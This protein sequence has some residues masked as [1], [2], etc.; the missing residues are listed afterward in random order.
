VKSLHRTARIPLRR[1]GSLHVGLVADTHSL[2]HQDG[3]AFLE[4]AEP[5]LILHA[6][7]IGDLQVLAQLETLAPVHAVRGN[8]DVRAAELP[9]VLTVEFEHQGTLAFT[10]LLLHI[11]VAGARIRADASRLAHAAGA[12]LIVCGHSHIPFATQ[13]RGLTL[14]NPGSM[15]PRRFRL[16]IV[17]GLMNLTAT[18]VT[19]R[20]VDC[21]TGADWKP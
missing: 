10:L 11:A 6:G 20:H 7:D 13:E 5:D 4:A 19:F 17:F 8:I 18:G 14:F 16:P 15:G 9:D 21:E 12:R 1:D 2:P 3:L